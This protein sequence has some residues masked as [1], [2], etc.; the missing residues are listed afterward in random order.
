M[1]GLEQCT[2][3]DDMVAFLQG[4]APGVTTGAVALVRV[5]GLGAEPGSVVTCDGLATEGVGF[6]EKMGRGT[7]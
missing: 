5:T 7:L 4:R 1:P 6:L 3:S 2:S